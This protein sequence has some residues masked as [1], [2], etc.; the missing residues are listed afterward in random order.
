[1]SYCSLGER[2]RNI[3]IVIRHWSSHIDLITSLLLLLAEPFVEAAD[4]PINA[5]NL[6]GQYPILEYRLLVPILRL[7]T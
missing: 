2:R 4:L 1:M 5:E 7:L 6:V 3:S